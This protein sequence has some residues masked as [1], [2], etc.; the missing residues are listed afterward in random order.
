M[1]VMNTVTGVLD[2]TRQALMYLLRGSERFRS[3]PADR[4]VTE[5]LDALYGE[6]G[7]KARIDPVL[8]RCQACPVVPE[9]W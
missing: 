9:D 4:R 2:F 7:E 8:K 1:A 5:V 3:K 6:G